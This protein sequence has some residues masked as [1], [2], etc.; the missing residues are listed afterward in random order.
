ML[1]G[2]LAGPTTV[3]HDR[4][5]MRRS[6]RVAVALLSGLGLYGVGCARVACVFGRRSSSVSTP[7]T[8]GTGDSAGATAAAG[9]G[10]TQHHRSE[11]VHRGTGH[12]QV[13][14]QREGLRL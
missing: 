3:S 1:W 4:Y 5:R 10:K 11:E 14:Q 6:R 12:R 9:V 13:V 8:R 2:P 7:G